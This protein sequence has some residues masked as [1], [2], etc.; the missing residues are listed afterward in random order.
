MFDSSSCAIM[1]FITEYINDR[2]CHTNK[3]ICSRGFAAAA[4]TE[5]VNLCHAIYVSVT[6]SEKRDCQE[7]VKVVW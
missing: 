2:G 6:A 5:Y 1:Q 4:K 7:K 3:C